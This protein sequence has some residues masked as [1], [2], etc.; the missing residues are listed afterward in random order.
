MS[1]TRGIPAYLLL[2]LVFGLAGWAILRLGNGPI[3]SGTGIATTEV[4]VEG[5]ALGPLPTLLIQ[6]VTIMVACLL[7][8]H[9][10]RKLG[11]PAVVGQMAAGILLGPSVLGWAWPAAETFLFPSD[12]LSN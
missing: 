4:A 2:L 3:P 10:F 8:G 1:K 7:C 11:Q 12:S 6:L 5:K 9:L